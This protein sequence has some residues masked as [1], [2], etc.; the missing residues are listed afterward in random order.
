MPIQYY[1]APSYG[2]GMGGPPN[3]T[4]E[5]HTVGTDYNTQTFSMSELV[6]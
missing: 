2:K 3:T 4:C 5:W 1:P 6:G